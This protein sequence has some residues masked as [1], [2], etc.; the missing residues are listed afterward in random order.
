MKRKVQSKFLFLFNK[1]PVPYCKAYKYL[2]CFINEH[3][4]YNYTAEVQAD[5]AGRALSSLITKMI[6]NKGFP[7]SIYNILYQSCI[8]SISQYGSEVYGFEKF[9]SAFKLHLRA[10]RAFLGLPKNV[11]SVGLISELNWLLPRYQSHVKMIQFYNRILCTP[12]NRL[13]YRIYVWDR[14]L[15][16]SKQINTWSAEIK[17]ILYEH[18]L[19]QIF[20]QNQIFPLKQTIMKLKT[21][22]YEKQQ[23]ILTSWG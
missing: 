10:A 3:L 5:S 15:N 4:D 21:S 11:T 16:E 8:C 17:S 20:D 23:Q 9:D 12:S 14:N 22:M 13:L 18:N 7:F 1:R 2:G 6:K 19:A